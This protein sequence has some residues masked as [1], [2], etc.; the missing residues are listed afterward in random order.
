MGITLEA[1]DN[2]RE[3]TGVS[4]RHAYEALQASDG[5]VVN[6]IIALEDR[7]PFGSSWLRGRG[8]ELGSGIRQLVEEGNAT[9][10]VVRSPAGHTVVEVPATIAVASSLIFPLATVAGVAAALVGHASIALER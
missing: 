1:I 2:V 9:R 4:Y 7:G 10:V 8:K 5:D 3:R 6:A